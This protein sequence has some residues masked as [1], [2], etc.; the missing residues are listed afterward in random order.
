[1]AIYDLS[2]YI[3]NTPSVN[4]QISQFV[5]P[6]A[7]NLAVDAGDSVAYAA[8]APDD[9]VDINMR[10]NGVYI[11]TMTFLISSQT[12][13]FVGVVST[14]FAAGDIIS[15]HTPFSM[16]ALTHLSWNLTLTTV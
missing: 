1:M 12:A 9:Q 2:G 6:R 15:L 7:L 8:S 14:D 3:L 16:N 10:K 11:G 4:T 5:C 13:I